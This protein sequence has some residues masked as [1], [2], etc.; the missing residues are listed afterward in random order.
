MKG[1]KGSKYKMSIKG[2]KRDKETSLKE[3]KW[4]SNKYKNC[5][6]RTTDK[7]GLSKQLDGTS[8]HRQMG[9]HTH[10]NK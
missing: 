1:Q 3:Y 5:V 6:G 9:T 2:E 8:Q 4:P 7:T 10:K